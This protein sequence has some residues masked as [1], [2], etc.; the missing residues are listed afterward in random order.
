MPASAK[1]RKRYR[2]GAAV[3]KARLARLGKQPVSET[4]DAVRFRNHEALTALVSGTAGKREWADVAEAINVAIVLC[5][6][7]YEE[8][9]QRAMLLRAAVAH[10]RC[11]A[12]F[13]N[14]NKYGYSGEEL[15]AVNTAMEVHDAQL[16]DITFAEL[17]RA[18]AEVK[19]RQA[20][21]PTLTP[22]NVYER[23]EAYAK[24]AHDA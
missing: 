16:A 4:C 19:R 21:Q 17:C 14:Q 8:P 1:P 22:K 11:G 7:L 9:L 6:T 15:V 2:P 20:T 12:R 10:A 24:Q 3:N 18:H 23:Q 13:L 5:E